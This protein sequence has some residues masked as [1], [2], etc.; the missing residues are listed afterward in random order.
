MS[1]QGGKCRLDRDEEEAKHYG[2]PTPGASA[3][4]GVPV[5]ESIGGQP[6]GLLLIDVDPPAAPVSV[7]VPV[8]PGRRGFRPGAH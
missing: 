7:V 5:P 8:H 6:S 1:S 3:I 4:E 2:E